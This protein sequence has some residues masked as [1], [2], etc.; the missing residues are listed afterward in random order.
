MGPVTAVTAAWM[1]E[2]WDERTGL[3]WNPPGSF[4]GEQVD[5]VVGG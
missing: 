1:D 3:L 4:E 5:A 2:A